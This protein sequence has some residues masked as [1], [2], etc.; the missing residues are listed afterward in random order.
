MKVYNREADCTYLIAPIVLIMIT[1]IVLS[2]GIYREVNGI[3]QIVPLQL[4]WCIVQ[5]KLQSDPPNNNDK[6]HVQDP[7]LLQHELESNA[8]VVQDFLTST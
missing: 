8:V 7:E 1:R 4:T 6:R 3:Y 2:M 5:D